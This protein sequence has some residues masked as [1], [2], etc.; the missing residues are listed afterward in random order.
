MDIDN[1]ICKICKAVKP[2]SE[3]YKKG[4][5][6]RSECKICGKIAYKEWKDDNIEKYKESRKKYREDNKQRIID[7]NTKN[8]NEISLYKKDHYIKNREHIIDQVSDYKKNNYELIVENSKKYYENNK[9]IILEKQKI[10]LK[11]RRKKFPHIFIHRSILTRYLKWI[12]ENKMDKTSTILGYT[13]GDLKI[14]I[15][16]IFKEGMCWSNYGEWHIDH[17]RPICSF[18][19]NTSPSIVNDLSNLQPLWA[20]ENLSKGGKYE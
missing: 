14:H 2:L 20:Y 5:W 6:H 7:Y 17:I 11:E 1:K 18:D 13:S 16:S 19:K 9:D 12:N 8:K 3:F 4:K 15:E 10:Y